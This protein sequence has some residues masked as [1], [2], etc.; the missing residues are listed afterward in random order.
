MRPSG[1][2]GRKVLVLGDDTRA[3]LSVVRSLGRAGIEVHVAWFR[4]GAP[5]LRSRYISKPHHL[6]AYRPGRDEWK[7]ALAGLMR[8][9]RFE[10]VVPCDDQRGLPLAAHRAELERCGRIWVPSSDA[11]DVLADKHRTIELA[12]SLGVPV[13]R[14][15]LVAERRR[16]A[17]L[18]D[19]FAPPLILKPPASYRVGDVE[20]RRSVRRADSWEAAGLLLDEMLVDGPVA[21]QEFCRGQGVGVELLLCDGAP[22]LAFQ[23][24]RLHEPPHGGG[25]SYRRGVPVSPELLDAAQRL[26]GA[27]RY[28]GVAMVEFKRDLATGRWVL[29][30]VNARFWGSLPLALAS[31]ADFPLALFQL[32][33]DGKRDF[34]AGARVGLCAR[35]LR[36]D[37]KWHLANLR[38]DRSDPTLNTKRWRSVAGETCRSLLT[39]RER[40]DTLTFDDPAP[41]LAE[42]GQL[43]AAAARR[44]RRVAAG[45][46]LRARR[47]RQLQLAARE[48]LALARRV[49]FVCNGNIGRSPF[50]AA[51]AGRLLGDGREIA[52]AGFLQGGRRSPADAVVAAAAW[53][54]DLSA[55]RS[56][57]V[58]PELVRESDAIFVFDLGNYR[59]LVA[60]FPDARSRIHLFGA[61]DAGG[62]LFIADPW[63]RGPDAYAAIYRRIAETLSVAIKR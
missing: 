27:L 22:L 4:D 53:H 48:Q 34:T 25:S 8:T 41:G 12:E 29:L 43:V 44:G 38:A 3:F 19:K 49:L 2:T 56:H 24:V 11:L 15:V 23:H 39:G 26:L 47:R 59:R 20:V 1:P 37:A 10:L 62:S 17:T 61:L 31:G 63:G 33:V 36:A 58:S 5:A 50:A 45:I 7:N 9:E 60:R 32:L 55:H 30:E 57:V 13:P 16:L 52:S 18:R 35:N 54:V 42:A 40:I 46:P 14:Q 51:L 21:V 28:T 6:P